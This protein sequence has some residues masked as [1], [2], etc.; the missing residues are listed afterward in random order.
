MNFLKRLW[1][2]RLVRVFVWIVGSLLT[3]YILSCSWVNYT[4]GKRW[5]AAQDEM[6]R[7]GEKLDFHALLRDPVPDEKN[8]CSL[9]PL[10]DLTV[11]VDHDATKGEPG[12]KRKRLEELALPKGDRVGVIKLSERP[13][14]VRGPTLGR[15]MDLKAWADWLR[16]E[17]SLPM[18]PDSGNAARDILAGLSKQDAL[19][20]E[21]VAG[22]NRTEACWTPQW[23]MTELPDNL[24]A[25]LV[26]HYGATQGMTA[27]LSLRAIAEIHAGE[28]ANACEL[29]LVELRVAQASMN[30]PFLI[31]TLVGYTQN[32]RAAGG[33]WEMCEAHAGT[34]EDFRR[35]QAELSRFDFRASILAAFRG[36]MAASA[37]T[38]QWMKKSK[39]AG[40]FAVLNMDPS[41]QGTGWLSKVLW[42][43]VPTGWMDTNDATMVRLEF[44]HVIKPLRDQGLRAAMEEGA[45]L[46]KELQRRKADQNAFLMLF[47]DA[48]MAALSLPAAGTLVTRTAYVASV[49]NQA[50]IACALERWFIEHKSYPDSLEELTRAGEKLPNDP[51]TGEPIHYRKTPDGRYKLWCVGFDGKDDGGKRVLNPKNPDSTKFSDP[52]YKGDWVWSYQPGE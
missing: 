44:Q 42:S 49:N 32:A 5:Q 2:S 30:D 27:G 40:M 50:I 24:F 34:L 17:G 19:C 35:L 8:F 45:L 13:A 7:E 14:Q 48:F 26:P 21:L 12:A 51:L 43:T 22:L 47:D 31:G 9:P 36:E 15:P 39:G 1:K 20:A 46:D 11:A 29:V 3:L 52:A 16:Q 25:V 37:Q 41:S 28:S 18:P 4:G 38:L 33:I 23:K 10:K 6:K